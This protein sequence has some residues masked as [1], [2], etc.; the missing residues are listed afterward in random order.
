MDCFHVCPEPQ[1]LREP[2]LNHNHSPLVL[3][4]ACISCGRCM[5]VCAEQVFEFKTRF[6]RSGDKQ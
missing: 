2:V 3:S 1:V 6:H 5:D 4:K